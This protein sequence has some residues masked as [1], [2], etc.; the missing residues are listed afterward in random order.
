MKSRIL[1][2]RYVV[3][4]WGSRKATDEIDDFGKKIRRKSGKESKDYG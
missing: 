4:L 2:K 1:A 3:D